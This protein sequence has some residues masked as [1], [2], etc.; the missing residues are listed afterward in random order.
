MRVTS[1]RLGALAA[2][3]CALLVLPAS[4][5]PILSGNATIAFT[6][7]FGGGPGSVTASDVVQIGAG[8]EIQWGDGTDIGTNVLLDFEYLDLDGLTITYKIQ[9]GSNVGAIQPGYGDNGMVS[10]VFTFSGLTFTP[11]ASI[12][13]VAPSFTDVL[14]DPGK[15]GFTANSVTIS[16]LQSFLIKESSENTG[17]ITIRLVTETEPPT[18]A[19]EPATLA[20]LGIGLLAGARRAAR[21][22]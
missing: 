5:A 12:V 1:L 14:G 18:P 9:G 8:P 17:F 2:L 15:I 4:A 22:R 16:D 10:G 20:L 11:G 13:S 6:G 21:K 3:I 19:P 7:D